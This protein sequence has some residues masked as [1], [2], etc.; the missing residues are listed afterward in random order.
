MSKISVVINT[1]QAERHLRRV[2]ESVR[3]FDEV[4]VCDMES[5]DGTVA[6]AREFGCR[7]VTFPKADHVCAEPARTF[8][9]Q[10]ATSEWVLV[11]DADELVT[12]ALRQYLYAYIE[13][14]SHKC[15]LYIPRRNFSAGRWARSTYPDYQ[16]RFF[17]REGTVWPPYVHTFPTVAG[18]VE[19]IAKEREDLALTHLPH[20][21]Y[22][23]IDRMNRYSENELKK[24]AGKHVTFLKILCE[25]A[26]RFVLY[27]IIKAGFLQGTIGFNRAA[28]NAIYKYYVLRKLWEAEQMKKVTL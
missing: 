6:V 10:S 22:D 15:G 14:E 7:V 23:E 5:T 18:P 9:I 2:L 16:L 8:A 26:F 12:D 11:V 20:T 24:R 13:Q 28:S 3:G 27:Y 4:V 17:R 1:Y 19:Y 21:V 25:P